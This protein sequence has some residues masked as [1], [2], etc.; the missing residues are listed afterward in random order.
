ML[1]METTETSK[2]MRSK[3]EL[4]RDAKKLDGIDLNLQMIIASLA[5]E[6]LSK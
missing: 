2:S 3:D 4:S 6:T 5:K 1:M